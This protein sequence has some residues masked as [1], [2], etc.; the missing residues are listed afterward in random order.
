MRLALFAVLLAASFPTASAR[1]ETH[2]VVID[3]FQFKPRT[4]KVKP[5]DTIVWTNQDRMEHSATAD[6]GT[7]DSKAIA[8]KQQWSWVAG[9]PGTY[10]YACSF[11]AT[12][13]GTI[14]VGP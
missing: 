9:K 13:R 1:A 14:E 6:D 3:W 2:E 4:L 12:M 5:G 11:H 7:F 10:P 8:R